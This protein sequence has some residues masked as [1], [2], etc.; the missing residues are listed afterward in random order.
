MNGT[1]RDGVAVAAA[2]VADGNKK[3]ASAKAAVRRR[4]RVPLRCVLMPEP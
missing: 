2:G 1:V 4:D 3:I